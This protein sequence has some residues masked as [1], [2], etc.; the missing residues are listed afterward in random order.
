M[1]VDDEELRFVKGSALGIFDWSRGLNPR[2][3]VHFWATGTGVLTEE[4]K[5]VSFSAGYG[6]ADN[7]SGTEN[8]FFINTTLYK[9][10]QVTFHIQPRDWLLPW[11]F[12]SDDGTLEM[13]FTPLLERHEKRSV[14]FH[15]IK[16]R[17]FFGH[18]SGHFTLPQG[19]NLT[20]SDIPG[21]AE[22]TKNHL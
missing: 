15:T 10:N 18:Y 5:Q 3:D 20:F 7:S 9:L 4:G 13:T 1:Q 12:T 8:A 2:S 14:L 6:T 17:L 16:Q 22:Q 19:V 21:M 11:R